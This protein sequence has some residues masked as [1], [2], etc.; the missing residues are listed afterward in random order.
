MYSWSIA[1]CKG[2]LS[3]STR[4]PTDF[5]CILAIMP[6]IIPGENHKGIQMMQANAI[7]VLNK[8]NL[9][10]CFCNS[11]CHIGLLLSISATKKSTRPLI[12]S[13]ND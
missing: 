7:L 10:D 4:S 8:N 11:T 1:V 2:R 5:K 9:V 13:L 3:N 12:D 6:R